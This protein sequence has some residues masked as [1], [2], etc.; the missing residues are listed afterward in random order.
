MSGVLEFIYT[1][2]LG[3]MR[4]LVD[5]FWSLYAGT[6]NTGIWQWIVKNWKIWLVILLVG[7]LVVDWLMWVVR[8]R[9]YRVLF[10][11]FRRA[12]APA[13]EEAWDSGV[14]YYAPETAQ[15]TDP[16]EWG[17]AT[18][19][20]LS[21]IDPNWA[22]DVV[23]DEENTPLYDPEYDPHTGPYEQVYEEP[24]QAQ[25]YAEEAEEMG[26]WGEM[27]DE[28]TDE[29]WADESVA[30][31]Q[32]D[33]GAVDPTTYIAPASYGYQAFTPKFAG[34][35]FEN[36]QPAFVEP[37]EAEAQ[38][39]DD[40]YEEDVV[41]T[42]PDAQAYAEEPDAP[43]D[44][45]PGFDP[46]APYDA[47]DP[48]EVAAMTGDV[49]PAAP[50]EDTGPLLYGR[51]GLWPGQMP[52]VA[53]MADAQDEG[54]IELSPEPV[55]APYDPLFN[56][57]APR[58]GDEPPRRRRRR[59][60]EH[61]AS[62]TDPIA[63]APQ[64]E[65]VPSWAQGRRARNTIAQIQNEKDPLA[66]TRPSRVVRPPSE[67]EG[68]EPDGTPADGKRK[69]R[70]QEPRT[71]TGKPAR[72]RGLFRLTSVEEEAI[73]GLPPLDLTDPFLPAARP[74]DVDFAPD[75]GEEYED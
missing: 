35:R 28:Q 33:A 51:P 73:A 59:L 44:M 50:D 22:G 45:P 29:T 14:G 39:Y 41:I 1:L 55:H 49:P 10:S 42:Q 48:G 4:G 15:D 19:A 70:R 3:W 20:T 67:M 6:G 58:A 8:W 38:A 23:I 60:H 11:R 32:E 46:F 17:D 54:E 65:P 34:A 64:E 68:D 26:Y 62:D 7:G 5:W 57:D 37:E 27:A 56:P 43:M 47:Y 24:A 71:V 16:S 40:D 25:P 9:P 2:L 31:E 66:D 74:D 18:F 52:P 53:G 36:T 30:Y 63:A 12:P 69:R 75:D 61:V 21:E 13:A 72:R